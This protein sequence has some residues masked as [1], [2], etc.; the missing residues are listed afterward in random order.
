[1]LAP[2]IPELSYRQFLLQ[3]L[4]LQDGHYRWRI[5]LDIFYKMAP[6][7]AAFPEIAALQPYQGET[8]F[9]AGQNSN[10]VTAES[11]GKPFPSAQI[12]IIANAGHWLHVQQPVEFVEL[13][14]NFL[15]KS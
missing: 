14:E 6:N 8:L 11:I 10:F 7:I 1:V 5:D 13:V 3:N 15:Q 2:A 9:I 12:K 4:I